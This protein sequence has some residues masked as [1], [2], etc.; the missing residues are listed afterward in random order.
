MEDNRFFELAARYLSNEISFE[1]MSKLKDYLNDKKYQEL[2]SKIEAEWHE[3]N[4][5]SSSAK[6]S[7][8]RGLKLLRTKIRKYDPGFSPKPSFL[9][10][11]YLAGASNPLRI[12]ASF[13]LFTLI[14]VSAFYVSTQLNHSPSPNEWQ[15]KV[16]EPGQKLVLTLFDGTKITLNAD[17]KLKYPS[18]FSKKS[19]DVYLQGEA[20]FEVA[21]NAGKPFIVHMGNLSATVLG[22]KFNISAFPEDKEI[23]VSLVEGRLKVS[24]TGA[25]LK[26]KPVILTPKEQ[27]SFD[28]I[29]DKMTLSDFNV[30]QVI[31]WKDNML[32]FENEPISSVFEKLDRAFG[33]K[34]ECENK[35][36]ETKRIKAYF[37]NESLWTVVNVIKSAIGYNYKIVNGNGEIKKVVFYR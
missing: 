14:A 30:A 32:I 7:E 15:E 28:T 36:M 5:K 2:F 10:R 16:T 3:V 35:M 19:R 27:I 18:Q 33:V 20:Y 11:V 21:H 4:D 13:V 29:N 9:R 8:E 24:D 26:Q 31:G 22:T 34:F 25:R 17:S 37:K 1:E 23:T 6:F 12:A